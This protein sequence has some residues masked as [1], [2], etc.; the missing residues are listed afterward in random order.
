M[1]NG[2]V[3]CDGV[4]TRQ[5]FCPSKKCVEP[6]RY[7]PTADCIMLGQQVAATFC[8]ASICASPASHHPSLTSTK[9]MPSD[10]KIEISASL[11]RKLHRIHRQRTDLDGQIARGPRQ[12]AAGK[13]LVAKAEADMLSVKE[14]LKKAIE[15]YNK[16]E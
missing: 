8:E 3:C 10:P 11:L 4:A 13:T 7:T 16:K 14:A 1:L 15:S 5:V 12:V 6:K 2:Q 9:P